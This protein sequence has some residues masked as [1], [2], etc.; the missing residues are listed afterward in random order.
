MRPWA[1]LVLFGLLGAGCAAPRAL[2]GA[3]T[4]TP[5]DREYGLRRVAAVESASCADPAA[6]PAAQAELIEALSRTGRVAALGPAAVGAR[7]DLH[8]RMRLRVEEFR[9]RRDVEVVVTVT[10]LAAQRG[11]QLAARSETGRARRGRPGG[12]AEARRRALRDA[13]SRLAGPLA[14]AIAAVP[15]SASVEQVQGDLLQLSAPAGL[16]GGLELECFHVGRPIPDPKTGEILGHEE[17]FLGRAVVLP[18]EAGGAAVARLSAPTGVPASS[19]S[20]CRAISDGRRS[21]R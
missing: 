8:A 21:P 1:P 20:I 3:G 10:A 17:L 6:C 2:P 16:P 7:G 11:T 13:F 15:W 18:A 12:G 4:G 9:E 19:G 14:D 5:P